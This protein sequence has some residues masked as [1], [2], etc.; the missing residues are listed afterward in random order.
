M[1]RVLV[2]ESIDV[3]TTIPGRIDPCLIMFRLCFLDP[4]WSPLQQN[5]VVEV[6]VVEWYLEF[7]SCMQVRPGRN[8]GRRAELLL[9]WREAVFQCVEIMIWRWR[10][11][12][13][14]CTRII[15]QKAIAD[16]GWKL[17]VAKHAMPSNLQGWAA[18]STNAY[19]RHAKILARLAFATLSCPTDSSHCEPY[20]A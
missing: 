14:A 13:T 11:G 6:M 4:L 12:S 18:V 7:G 17:K 19:P 16:V 1:E 3:S 9:C 2:F 20:K 5:V 10:Q 15:F 8:L